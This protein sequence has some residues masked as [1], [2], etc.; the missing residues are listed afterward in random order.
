MPSLIVDTMDLLSACGSERVIVSV[1]ASVAD[2]G[3]SSGASGYVASIDR[4]W[5]WRNDG[6]EMRQPDHDETSE[7]AAVSARPWETGD[8]GHKAL[9]PPS[10]TI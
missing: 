6:D 4:Y 9:C 10:D 1:G 8:G 7:P 2:S 5:E 3:G